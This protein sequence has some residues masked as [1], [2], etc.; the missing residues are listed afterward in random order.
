LENIED[1]ETIKNH[2]I[3]ETCTLSIIRNQE[4]EVNLDEVSPH[5]I[6]E[7]DFDK[8]LERECDSHI[9][10]R[11]GVSYMKSLSMDEARKQKVSSMAHNIE[12]QEPPLMDI[13][14][15]YSCGPIEEK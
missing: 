12:D 14:E 11:C 13:Y 2:E 8:N 5:G 15:E 3:E 7:E 6:D 9:P 10:Y 4:C 1:D